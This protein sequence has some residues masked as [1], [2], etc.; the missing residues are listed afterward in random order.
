ML[1]FI[2]ASHLAGQKPSPWWTII[3]DIHLLHSTYFKGYTNYLHSFVA[4][5]QK[6]PLSWYFYPLSLKNHKRE[7]S[8]SRKLCYLD[9]KIDFYTEIIVLSLPNADAV[10]RRLKKI[11]SIVFKLSTS[12]QEDTS[13]KSLEKLLSQFSKED[14]ISFIE[15]VS[16]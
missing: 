15:Y 12:N 13:N 8:Q 1:N 10:T 11:V 6:S 4:L 14:R 3:H 7:E 5:H 16:S 2:D 9:K